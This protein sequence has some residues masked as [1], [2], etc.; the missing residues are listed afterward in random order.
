MYNIYPVYIYIYIYIYIYRFF[1][2]GRMGGVPPP[3]KNLLIP[4]S[5]P[6]QKSIQHN[7]KI[8]TSF[9]VVVIP[10]VPFSF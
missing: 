3:A 10:P 2:T 9:L 7:K 1:P 4:P 6:H 5:A 8:K